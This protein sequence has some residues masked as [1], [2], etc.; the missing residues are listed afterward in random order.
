MS[1][2]EEEALHVIVVEGIHRLGESPFLEVEMSTMGSLP[3]MKRIFIT[4][5]ACSLRQ[6]KTS[7]HPVKV[8]TQ[9]CEQKYRLAFGI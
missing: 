3:L 6:G 8:S 1:S 7:I 4:S 5:L 2:D 9:T